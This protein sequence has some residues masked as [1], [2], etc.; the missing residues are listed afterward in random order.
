MK[1]S[2]AREKRINKPILKIVKVLIIVLLWIVAINGLIKGYNLYKHFE[3]YPQTTFERNVYEPPT[4]EELIKVNMY[5]SVV[6]N[7]NFGLLL[8][9][10]YLTVDY[11]YDPKNHFITKIKEKFTKLRDNC[12]I[13][14]FKEFCKRMEE[15]KEEKEN[16]E[17]KENEIW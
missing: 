6:R 4:E 10:I 11:F 16:Q 1:Q 8:V 3:E 13:P 2:L 9:F 17:E 15:D 5:N 14:I 7:V 12:N